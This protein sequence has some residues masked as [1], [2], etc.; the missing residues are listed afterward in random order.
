[1]NT[2]TNPTI[3]PLHMPHKTALRISHIVYGRENTGQRVTYLVDSKGD[4]TDREI[5]EGVVLRRWRAR[6]TAGHRFG[7]DRMAPSTWRA[8]PRVLGH[9]VSRWPALTE[10]EITARKEQAL[11]ELNALLIDVPAPNAIV[12]LIAVCGVDRLHQLVARHDDP[13]RKDSPGVPDLFLF[14]WALDGRRV[15]G[16]FVEVKKPEERL[17]SSQVAELAFLNELGLKARELRLI[18]RVKPA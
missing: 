16:R 11:P 5:A 2:S 15:L 18:E 14:A 6:K 17:L 13:A 12:A 8:L 10:A 4:G 1:M 3:N 9:D 7:G